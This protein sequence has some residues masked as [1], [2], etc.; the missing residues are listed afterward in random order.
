MH[1]MV[2]TRPDIAFVVCVVIQ[3]LSKGGPMHWYAVKRI[4]RYWMHDAFLVVPCGHKYCIEGE[5]QCGLGKRCK[6]AKIHHRIRV[7]SWKWSHLMEL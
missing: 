2:G 4:L 1:V 6:R 3:H 7:F 5:M